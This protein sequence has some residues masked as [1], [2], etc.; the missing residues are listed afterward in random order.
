MNFIIV[1]FLERIVKNE[2]DDLIRKENKL[3]IKCLL[4]SSKIYT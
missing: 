4:K 3:K 2:F 1:H